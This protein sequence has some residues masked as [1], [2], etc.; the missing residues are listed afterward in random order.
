MYQTTQFAFFQRWNFNHLDSDIFYE[1]MTSIALKNSSA[2]ED[3]SFQNMGVVKETCVASTLIVSPPLRNKSAINRPDANAR[4]DTPSL[5][6]LFP[7][8]RRYRTFCLRLVARETAL[9]SPWY[10]GIRAGDNRSDNAFWDNTGNRVAH[11]P[12]VIMKTE[13]SFLIGLSYQITWHCDPCGQVSV[14]SF[15]A[16]RV[17]DFDL[18]SSHKSRPGSNTP[19]LY[20]YCILVLH[21]ICI[22]DL[23]AEKKLYANSKLIIILTNRKETPNIK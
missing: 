6:V 16:A 11:F 20:G 10:R 3:L 22:Q 23:C 15:L 5:T 18:S 4:S 17:P 8:C 14:L 1:P 7:G 21:T 9:S 2:A 13:N 19:L 12:E